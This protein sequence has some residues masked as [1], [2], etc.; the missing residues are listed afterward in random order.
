MTRPGSG[1]RKRKHDQRIMI[2]VRFAESGEGGDPPRPKSGEREEE[3]GAAQ[4]NIII[5]GVVR[6]S[7]ASHT[8]P[9]CI[10]RQGCSCCSQCYWF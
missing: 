7:I 3:E 9:H 10:A 2:F 8:Q 5:G 6:P 4:E 1:W